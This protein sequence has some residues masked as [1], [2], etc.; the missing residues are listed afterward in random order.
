[1]IINREFARASHETFTIKPISALLDRYV[2]DG[3]G[4]ADP[5]AGWNSKAQYTNDHNPLRNSKYHLEAEEFCK[6]DEFQT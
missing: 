6:L 2:K 4:W 3:M 5:F 1:M